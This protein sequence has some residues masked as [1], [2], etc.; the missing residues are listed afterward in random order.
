MRPNDKISSYNVNFIY[1]TSQLGQRNSVLCYCYYQSLSNQIQDPISTWEQGKPILFQNMY[2]LAMTIDHHYW[3]CNCKC[4]HI[5][6]VEREALKSHFQKQGK[7]SS[8]SNATVP[9]NKANTFLMASS[10]KSSLSK[11]LFPALKK[12][13]NSSQVDFSSKLA[14]NGKLTSDKCK[15]YLEN[16]LY[17]Y[18]SIRD[19]KL[20]SCSKKQT[21]VMPKGHSVSATADS[22]KP[23]EKQ[24][25][26]PRTLHRLRATLNFL[27]Q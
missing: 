23:L 26:T 21:M 2:T 13:S 24:K 20:D 12:Q 8:T 15:K 16:N 5:R 6:Q 19:H 4:Y 7:A 10:A 27:V 3:E 22:E 1:Y 11:L 25:V 18:C 17:L 9:Q 14:S